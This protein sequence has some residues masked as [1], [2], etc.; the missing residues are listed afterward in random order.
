[1]YVGNGPDNQSAKNAVE[2]REKLI[3]QWKS[4]PFSRVAAVIR[5]ESMEF[6][7]SADWE[8]SMLESARLSW[9]A[10]DFID[11]LMAVSKS[12]PEDISIKEAN[13]IWPSGFAIFQK[14]VLGTDALN[15]GLTLEIHAIGWAPVRVGNIGGVP[16]VG[17]G[18]SNY[19]MIRVED[20][21]AS[22]RL[23]SFAPLMAAQLPDLNG[24]LQLEGCVWAP[25]GR[26]DWMADEKLGEGIQHEGKEADPTWIAS[27]VE[28]RRL[29]VALNVLMRQEKFV[30]R[31]QWQPTNRSA[32]KRARKFA[33]ADLRVEIVHLRTIRSD[34]ESGPA[35]SIGNY[36]HR[37]W[38][39]PFFRWQPYGPNRSLRRLQLI[40]GYIKGPA[41]KPF[42]SNPKVYSLDR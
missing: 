41:D 5:G 36:S 7:S 32:K 28:D 19:Q 24:Q 35:H 8:M 30:E 4:G 14:P 11:L 25:L 31:R 40:P 16:R 3:G 6:P 26:S 1:M 13:L 27:C 10:E 2:L 38:V 39:N 34:S 29:L 12:I 15:P 23:Q 20:G 18:I 22:E 21:I 42:K 37:W 9:V 33:N 17:I